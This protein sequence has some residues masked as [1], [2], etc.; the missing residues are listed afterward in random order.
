MQA[1][2]E[3]TLL[4]YK[5]SDEFMQLLEDKDKYSYYEFEGLIQAKLIKLLQEYKCSED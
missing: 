5:Y 4:T 1:N 2:I 3:Q